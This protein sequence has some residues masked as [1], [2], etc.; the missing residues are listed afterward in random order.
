MPKSFV[1]ALILAAVT[2][3]TSVAANAPAAA[4][5]T[6]MNSNSMMKIDCTQAS[7]LMTTAAKGNPP[8][9]TGNLDKDSMAMMMDREKGTAMMYKIE[10]ACGTDPKMKA[11]AAKQA[12]DA[13]ARME[14]FRNSGMSQ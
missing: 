9:M 13:D 8:P 6:M 7:S 10:A 3:S 12:T 4:A 2:A 5:D 14:M 11:M 1:Y